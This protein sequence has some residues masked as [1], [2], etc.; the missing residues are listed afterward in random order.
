MQTGRGPWMRALK[1]YSTTSWQRSVRGSEQ[2]GQVD[3]KMAG[4]SG[5]GVTQL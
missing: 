3:Q 1:P 4:V 5:R 2:C